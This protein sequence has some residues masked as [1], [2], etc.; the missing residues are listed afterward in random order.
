MRMLALSLLLAFGLSSCC[1][2]Q[3]DCAVI[4]LTI[5]YKDANGICQNTGYNDFLITQIN[6]I[7]QESEIL[8]NSPND[9]CRVYIY[10]DAAAWYIIES[11]S[12]NV[13]DTLRISSI[14]TS[15]GSRCCRCTYLDEISYSINGT[16][17]TN[18]DIQREI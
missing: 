3:C 2:V 7:T 9:P 10:P 6:R 16:T 17:Y 14:S 8:D 11:D 18:K 5:E 12:F 13:S 4:A 15:E 1:L